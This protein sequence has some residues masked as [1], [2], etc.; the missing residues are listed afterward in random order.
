[1]TLRDDRHT[2]CKQKQKQIFLIDTSVEIG[3]SQE[4]LT[5]KQVEGSRERRGPTSSSLFLSS[6]RVGAEPLLF[7]VPT[8]WG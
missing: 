8:T 1:M 3:K 4:A 7:R 5:V 6:W 2:L